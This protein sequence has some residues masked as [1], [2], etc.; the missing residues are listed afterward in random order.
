MLAKTG[1][2]TTYGIYINIKTKND[3]GEDEVIFSTANDYFGKASDY[4]KE[5]TNKG[6]IDANNDVI[7]V[8]VVETK[9]V[10]VSDDETS[11]TTEPAE[12]K[13]GYKN[14]IV[15][16][17]SHPVDNYKTVLYSN[18]K[19]FTVSG[20]SVAYKAPSTKTGTDYDYNYDDWTKEF[21]EYIFA[22]TATI[23]KNTITIKPENFFAP[24]KNVYVAIYDKD[25]NYM[26]VNGIPTYVT[27][28]AAKLE[29]ID[30]MLSKAETI[31]S[32]TAEAEIGNGSTA[33][34]FEFD[35]AY[36]SKTKTLAKYEIYVKNVEADNY[37]KTVTATEGSD[38][39][40]NSLSGSNGVV[41]YR[42]G[43]AKK[44]LIATALDDDAFKYGGTVDVVIVKEL[45]GIKTLYKTSLEDKKVSKLSIYDETYSLSVFASGSDQTV[46]ETAATGALACDTATTNQAQAYDINFKIDSDEW[47]KDVKV[48]VAGQ[49]NT[50]AGLTAN[51]KKATAYDP[52]KV[53]YNPA[54]PSTA[55][56]EFTN[57]FWF[58]NDKI[59]FTVTDTSGNE[60]VYTV[61]I[62]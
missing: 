61:T 32:K 45:D 6:F 12:F 18:D 34:E 26:P 30:E 5:L 33:V 17:F 60:A 28:S 49:T 11:K 10:T 35:T 2:D 54:I 59:T 53:T 42:L 46:L 19:V 15:L 43:R 8:N 29:N 14:D 7:N 16:Q 62:K 31:K 21:E 37:T 58:V 27:D 20:S 48:D 4:E 9:V 40:G 41:S 23:D 57:A 39:K 25:G 52:I 47:I 36:S 51:D 24:S 22:A 55:T 38:D 1:S 56:V 44:T 3:K 50:N 13:K